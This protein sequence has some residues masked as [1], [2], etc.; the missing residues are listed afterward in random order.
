MLPWIMP[1]CFYIII[2]RMEKTDYIFGIHPVMEAIEAGKN[3]DKILIRRELTSDAVKDLINKAR[4][5]DIPVQRVPGEKLNRISMRNHQGV[6]AIACPVTYY[7]LDNLLAALY[8]EGKNPIAMMLDG[9]TDAGNFGAIARS[10]ECAGAD[11]IIIPEKGSASVTSD[12]VRASAGALLHIPVCR[13]KDLVEAVKT[14]QENGYKIVGASEKSATLYTDIDYTVPVAIVMG[15]EYSGI[16][17][18][19]MR[20]CDELGKIPIKGKVGSLN[21]SV[22]AGVMLYEVV[23]Q[24]MA[25][26]LQ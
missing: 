8:E 26:I 3:L 18:D 9:V 25:N 6:I 17:A 4:R 21:V 23:K 11:L 15:S 16:S 5:Y 10:A 22:A 24:R 2:S 7:K 19:V 1:K 12:A 14:L 13:V 20:K